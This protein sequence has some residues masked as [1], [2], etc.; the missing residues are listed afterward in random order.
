M[1]TMTRWIL[2][3]FLLTGMAR[4][5]VNT[6]ILLASKPPR[7]LAAFGFF[8]DPSALR[9]SKGVVGYDITAPLFSDFAEKD[10]FIYTPE[11]LDP[12]TDGIL[13][14]PVGSALV[15]TFRYG[16]RKVETRVLI[17]KDTGWV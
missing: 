12:G 6:E 2:A 16:T 4:A 11:V 5:E 9:P 17:H 10:R 7:T 15:K 3:F 1:D 13:P 8:E 14:F